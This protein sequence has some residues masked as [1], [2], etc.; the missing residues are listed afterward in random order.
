M[1]YLML[2]LFLIGCGGQV[3]PQKDVTQPPV[4]CPLHSTVCNEDQAP[5]QLCCEAP[6]SCHNDHFGY[7]T[8]R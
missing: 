3:E 8:C 6:F 4:V 5:Y 2:L 7:Q 1:K